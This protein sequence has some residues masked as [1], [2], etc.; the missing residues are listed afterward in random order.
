RGR[1]RALP[2][3]PARQPK[4]YD[5]SYS[6]PCTLFQCFVEQL[7]HGVPR[8]AVRVGMI[9]ETRPAPSAGFGIGEAV[10]GAAVNL[11]APVDAGRPHF[12]LEGRA[13]LG[14]D[15]GILHADAGEHL[16][17]DVPRVLRP[18]RGE[19]GVKG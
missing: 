14:R 16:A 7:D 6:T 2:E 10:T 11:Q 5:A 3:H 15:D 19:A 18:C 13:L 12:L 17:L 8:P 1:S 4:R 9:E